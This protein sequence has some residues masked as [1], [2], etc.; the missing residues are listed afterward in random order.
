MRQASYPGVTSRPTMKPSRVLSIVVATLLVAPSLFADVTV[1][2]KNEYKFGAA[3]PGESLGPAAEAALSKLPTFSLIQI[4]GKLGRATQGP[5]TTVTDFEKQ[6]IT[7]IDPAHKQFAT[8]YIKDYE[9]E[10]VSLLE[11][12]IPAIRESARKS[13]DSMQSNFLTQKTGKTDTVGGIRVEETEMTFTVYMPPDPGAPSSTKSEH[14]PEPEV[15]LKMVVH[16][17]AA[18][19]SELNR[20]AVLKEFNN[21]YS[22]PAAIEAMNPSFEMEK[23]FGTIGNGFASMREELREKKALTLRTN[24]EIFMPW[25]AA[26]VARA[27]AKGNGQ[28]IPAA[29]DAPFLEMSS[30]VEEISDAPID[31]SVFEVPTDYRPVSVPELLKLYM[32]APRTPQDDDA[33]TPAASET[34]DVGAPRP[35]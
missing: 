4:K 3:S 23:M 11:E 32:P 14:A 12:S 1:R 10:V 28:V 18:L 13:V 30:K 17:W 2:Y 31:D 16:I 8:V 25:E 7:V 33:A 22:D 21:V 24:F 20:V 29:P 34:R 5:Y 35:K 27:Q 26:M 15:L 9:S 19:P 6:V